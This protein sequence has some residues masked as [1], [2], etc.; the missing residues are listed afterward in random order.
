[1]YFYSFPDFMPKKEEK[2]LLI[3]ESPA[4]SAT[5]KKYLGEHFEVKASYGHVADLPKKNMG[6]DVKNNFAVKY[7]ISPDKKKVIADLKKAAKLVDKV[8]IATDED[9]FPIK[10]SKNIEFDRIIEIVYCRFKSRK[11]K[12]ISFTFE[13]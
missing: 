2:H 7:E 8:W 4:K 1:M 6:V 10:R 9:R 3:V 5:I 12:K 13:R 11:N